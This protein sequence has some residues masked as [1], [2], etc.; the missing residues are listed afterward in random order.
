[1]ANEMMENKKQQMKA[2]L[3][4]PMAG[5]SAE[6]IAETRERA[7][8]ALEAKG[9][10]VVNTLFTDE[11]YSREAMEDRGVVQIPL[12]FL[13]KSLENMSLCHAVYFCKGWEKA[14]GCRIEHEAA[15]NY[16]LNII[17]EE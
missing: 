2:M 8:A 14:R 6:E 15:W 16:G 13:A 9:Y 11:W 17:Y 3:S 4:Q 12:C 1:M 5:K 7:I 10:S